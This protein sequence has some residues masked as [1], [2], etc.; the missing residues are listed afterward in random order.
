MGRTANGSR[1]VVGG[2]GCGAGI[3]R[4]VAEW[5]NGD[6]TVLFDALDR[7]GVRDLA[8]AFNARLVKEQKAGLRAPR[9]VVATE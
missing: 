7:E 5:A 9:M 4:L 2:E 3:Y 1:P 8:R 6:R